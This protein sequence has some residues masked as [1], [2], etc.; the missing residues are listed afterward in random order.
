[1]GQTL[2]NG[3]FLPNEG[4]RNCYTG[5]EGN[6]RAIDGYIGG[7]NVH[8]E[9]VVIHVS[10]ADRDKWDAVDNKADASALTAHTG[11]T[12][13]HVT[14]ADKQTWDTVTTKAND[15]D[16]VHKSG[17]ETIPGQKT[18]EAS[19]KGYNSDSAQNTVS[20]DLRTS[21]VARGNTQDGTDIFSL[22]FRDK[23]NESLMFFSCIKRSSGATAEYH[24]VNTVDNSNNV[25]S[26]SVSFNI[27]KDGSS[28]LQPEENNQISLGTSTKKWSAFN[29]INPGALFLPQDRSACVDISAY[30]TNTATGATNRIT[31][32]EDGYI[33][34]SLTD[35]VTVHFSS[36]TASN[37]T[38][39]SQTFARPTAG[40]VYCLFPVR[41]NDNVAVQWYTTAAAVTV[42]NAFFIPCK[43][44]A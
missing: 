14:A 43:G 37:L 21:K 6:W 2:T 38:H 4:E 9:D 36:Q 44:N 16:V 13:I 42:S 25:I 17:A 11:N 31:P 32:P 28:S 8:V 29:G 34:L 26:R 18:F 15:A 23:N 27:N 10:Q 7:Y 5:L 39:Y 24:T 1:M 41:K 40:V 19:I 22:G 3:I 20:I 33:Y 12:T 30:L 35:V